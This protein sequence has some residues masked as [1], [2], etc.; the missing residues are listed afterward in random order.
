[1]VTPEKLVELI[2]TPGGQPK[3]I[4]ICNLLQGSDADSM[5][6]EARYRIAG[7]DRVLLVEYDTGYRFCIL[8]EYPQELWETCD[9]F[10]LTVAYDREQVQAVVDEALDSNPDLEPEFGIW[11]LTNVHYGLYTQ[12]QVAK[13]IQAYG[14]WNSS[15]KAWQMLDTL[16]R[17]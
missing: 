7:T 5:G 4:E 11:K 15:A 3:T 9:L 14:H 12:T 10:E 1:M 17:H 13:T 2:S 6:T 16:N 8:A